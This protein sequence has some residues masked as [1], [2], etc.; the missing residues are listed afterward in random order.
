MWQMPHLSNLRD[1]AT[2]GGSQILGSVTRSWLTAGIEAAWGMPVWS[3][4]TE[5][6][7]AFRLLLLLVNPSFLHH[8]LNML[9][10]TNV[11]DRITVHRDDISGFSWGNR[12]EEFGMTD[13]VSGIHGCR[14]NC[15][16][17]GHS[18]LDHECKLTGVN[19][20]RTNACIC[21]K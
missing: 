8:E 10:L 1:R 21:A 18:I 19:P 13:K 3:V 11:G 15:L 20:M 7:P 12:T 16:H 6:R 5:G 2:C 9:E 14:L 17:R 4:S